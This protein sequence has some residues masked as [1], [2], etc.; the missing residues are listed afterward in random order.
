MIH[1]RHPDTLDCAP[2]CRRVLRGKY[3]IIQ[4]R[5]QRYVPRRAPCGANNVPLFDPYT[6]HALNRAPLDAQQAREQVAAGQAAVSEAI[7]DY[8]ATA[9]L[10]GFSPSELK[11]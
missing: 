7:A 9:A 4:S 8:L 1:L 11:Y 2:D 3:S 6:G 10:W 5:A